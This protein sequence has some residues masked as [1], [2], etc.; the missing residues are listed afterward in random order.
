MILNRRAA[1]LWATGAAFS[2]MALPPRCVRSGS[3]RI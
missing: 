2:G 1:I 3:A